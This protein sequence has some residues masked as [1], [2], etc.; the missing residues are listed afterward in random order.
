MTISEFI[1]NYQV[2]IDEIEPIVSAE[3]KSRMIMLRKFDIKNHFICLSL[4]TI[5]EY[6]ARGFIWSLLLLETL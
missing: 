5:S 6:E 2:F 1:D 3:M 4:T